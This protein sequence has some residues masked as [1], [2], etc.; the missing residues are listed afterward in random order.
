MIVNSFLGIRNTSPVRSIPD[1]ALSAAT[2]VDIDDAGILTRRNGCNKVAT[3]TNVTSAYSTRDKTAYVVANGILN[4]VGA[5]F[6]LFPLVAS[7]ATAFTDFG[8]VLFTNDGFR[9]QDNKVVDLTFPEPP[10]LSPTLVVTSGNWP[11]GQY[12]VTYCYRDND[13]GLEGPSSPIT[14]VTLTDNQMILVNP[15]PSYAGYTPVVYMTD[16]GGS[17]FYDTNG[18]Q[19]REAQILANQMPIGAPAIAFHN[20]SLWVASPQPN[21]STVI[22]HS[23][24]FFYHLFDYVQNYIIVP[25]E[26]RA[27]QS[28]AEGL[29]IGT[30]SN[31]YL[32]ADA[33]TPLANYGVPKGRAFI[34]TPD[35]K[36]KI[37][38]H[39]GV[40]EAMP[41]VN[42]TETKAL[43]APGV[44]CST[45]LVDQNGI[46][47][48]VALSD[49]SGLPYNTRF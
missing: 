29:V 17:V 47:K 2:D 30:D 9:I 5:D 31:I 43:F 44:Q 38:S 36:V 22:Y 6:S 41:F 10:S 1:N 15:V 48:F 42:F 34:R 46:Q 40:C 45:A 32:Y 19:L 12:S 11:A 13:D 14:T 35:D 18:V 26:V 25:G 49:G 20:S 33:L 24:P 39:R 16:A 7:T 3:Y 4:R 27:M 37:F 8:K 23:T 28:V 21:G